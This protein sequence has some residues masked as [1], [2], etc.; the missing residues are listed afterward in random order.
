MTND[1]LN[2]IDEMTRKQPTVPSEVAQALVSALLQARWEADNYRKLAAY[3]RGTQDAGDN[4]GA[5]V[6]L[7]AAT[8]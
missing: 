8:N 6:G 2:D 3:Y 7:R 1:Q 4:V 5:A